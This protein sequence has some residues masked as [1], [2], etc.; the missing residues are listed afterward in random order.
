MEI[1]RRKVF[2]LLA[3]VAGAS[4][5]PAPIMALAKKSTDVLRCPVTIRYRW[6]EKYTN[7]DNPHSG[8]PL[9]VDGVVRI[10]A[11]VT[12]NSCDLAGSI[13]IRED[14]KDKWFEFYKCGH[15]AE[16]GELYPKDGIH[17]AINVIAIC[18]H[19]HQQFA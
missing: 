7:H 19:F 18:T 15:P 12:S 16:F 1:S 5:V 2:A 6:E 13:L 8:M 11:Q 14:E 4:V 9:F 17:Y 3:S 10:F